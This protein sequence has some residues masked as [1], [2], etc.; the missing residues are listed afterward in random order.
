M[1]PLIN[2]LSKIS[3][4]ELNKKFSDLSKRFNQAYR[5]GPKQVIPQLQ[6]LMQDYQEEIKRRQAK[7]M[8][9]MMEKMDKDKNG[10]KGLRNI[11][12]IQ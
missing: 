10:G 7:A 5:F 3:D 8:Q 12:D 9:E 11:I 6:M 2:D 4:E 1:H